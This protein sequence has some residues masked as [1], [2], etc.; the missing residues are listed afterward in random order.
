MTK[1]QKAEKKKNRTVEQ[2]QK[3]NTRMERLRQLRKSRKEQKN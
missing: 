2:Q 1:E 3:I